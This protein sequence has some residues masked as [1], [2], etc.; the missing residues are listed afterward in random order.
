MISPV[1]VPGWFGIPVAMFLTCAGLVPQLPVAVTVTVD[2]AGITAG[3]R[4]VLLVPVPDKIAPGTEQA[5]LYAVAPGT[6]LIE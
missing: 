5:Q 4:M 3:N 2:P 6:E 1:I